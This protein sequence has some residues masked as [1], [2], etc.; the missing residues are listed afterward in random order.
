MT[1][2][3][4]VI[5]PT[6]QEQEALP[7]LLE[8]LR[9]QRDIALQIIV[10][11]GGSTDKSCAIA[12]EANAEVLQGPAGRARQLNAAWPRAKAPWLA[13]LH[14]DSRLRHPEAL[15]LALRALEREQTST[16]ERPVAGH[17]ML[18]FRGELP[19]RHPLACRVLELKTSLNRPGTTHGDQGFFLQRA[20]LER[21]GGFQEGLNFLEDHRLAERIRQDGRW[22]TLPIIIETS[23]RRFDV[24]GFRA[25]YTLMSA[26]MG[27]EH[28]RF[29]ELLACELY[30]PQHKTGELDMSVFYEQLRRAHGQLSMRRKLKLWRDVG[31]Y[32]R[33]NIWQL[34]LWIDAWQDAPPSPTKTPPWLERFDQHL[35]TKLDHPTLELLCGLAA[36]IYFMEAAPRLVARSAR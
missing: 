24:E 32:V 22:I 3:L 6:L 27:A 12:R 11:D 21:L 36:Y 1:P 26:I 7:K 23:S 14:A 2:Q 5:I 29:K 18:R 17:A 4:T 13:I 34:A 10:T 30:P 28:A 35:A 33:Q 19:H 15:S 31:A 20:H 8:E 9:Q 16:P 25:R